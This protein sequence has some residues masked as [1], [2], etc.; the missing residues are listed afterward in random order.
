[1]KAN[2]SKEA[3]VSNCR[4]TGSRNNTSNTAVQAGYRTA[5]T[6]NAA[7]SANPRATWQHPDD[8]SIVDLA[9]LLLDNEA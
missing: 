6:P 1:M 3:A 2:N 4:C 9:G 5:A 8:T 7:V